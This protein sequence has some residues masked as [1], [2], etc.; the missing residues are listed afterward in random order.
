MTKKARENFIKGTLKLQMVLETIEQDNYN[1][2]FGDKKTTSKKHRKPPSDSSSSE[3]Q[4]AYTHP[5]R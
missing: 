3:E 4:I 2:K 1:R 5:T